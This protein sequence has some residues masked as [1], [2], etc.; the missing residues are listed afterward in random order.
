MGSPIKTCAVKEVNMLDGLYDKGFKPETG[1]SDFRIQKDEKGYFVNSLSENTP[2]YLD[3]FYE[4]LEKAYITSMKDVEVCREK[5]THMDE[6]AAPELCGYLR[7]RIVIQKLVIKTIVRFYAE[8]QHIGVVMSPWCF[9]TVVL[10]K[11]EVHIE[12][13]RKGDIEDSD[14][15]A[16]PYYALKYIEEAYKK[17]LLETFELPPEAF[18]MRWQYAQMLKKYADILEDIKTSMTNVVNQVKN[19]GGKE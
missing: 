13:L 16:Y 7:A 14:M 10:E 3:A 19:L 11:V 4:F 12:R 8:R 6:Q 1:T 5:L 15:S 2:V 18:A 17:I 9:G